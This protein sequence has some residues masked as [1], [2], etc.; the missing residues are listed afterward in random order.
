MDHPVYTKA[1]ACVCVRARV[2]M[3]VP[4]A[5]IRIFTNRYRHFFHPIHH[6]HRE[7]HFHCL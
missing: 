4:S 7:S 3:F 2:C 6:N 1:I 5:L